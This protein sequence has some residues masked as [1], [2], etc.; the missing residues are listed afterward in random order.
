MSKISHKELQSFAEDGMNYPNPRTNKQRNYSEKLF[1]DARR[2]RQGAPRDVPEHNS[3]AQKMLSDMK[4][5][6]F[7]QRNEDSLY[8]PAI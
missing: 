7:M 5:Q 8:N 6:G 4:R 2:V 3:R 1:N